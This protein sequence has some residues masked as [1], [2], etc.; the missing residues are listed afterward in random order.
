[1]ARGLYEAVYGGH[2]DEAVLEISTWILDAGLAYYNLDAVIE[3][4]A[5]VHL[6]A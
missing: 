6:A 2:N 5:L 1:L 3:R 4:W